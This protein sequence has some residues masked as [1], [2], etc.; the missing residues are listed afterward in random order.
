M[1]A[2][3]P[4]V[5]FWLVPEQKM[6]ERLQQQVDALARR[7]GSPIFLPHLTLYSC[8]RTPEQ[9][10]LG[11]AAA[12]AEQATPLSLQVLGNGTDA[13]LSRTLFLHFAQSGALSSLHQ[14]LH[15]AVRQPSTYR[16]D[17]HLSLLYQDLSDAERDRLADELAMPLQKIRFDELRVVAIPQK[18]Q[19]LQDYVG[20]ETLL[21]VRLRE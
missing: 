19:S 11:L 9:V 12:L 3:L 17:P 10:E 4:R 5:A 2:S 7:Y 6:R 16:L 20:W 15:A 21:A 13:Q 18:L 8:Q 1:S 14:R